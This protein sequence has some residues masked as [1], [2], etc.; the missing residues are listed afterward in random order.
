MLRRV[1]WYILIDVS[2]IPRAL[3]IK[4]VSASETSVDV[5]QTKRRYIPEYGDLRIKI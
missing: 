5:Y 2:V 3:M 1:V 4:A